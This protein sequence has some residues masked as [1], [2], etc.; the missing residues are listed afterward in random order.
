MR[1]DNLWRKMAFVTFFILTTLIMNAQ[2]IIYTPLWKQADA[3]EQADKP[4]TR[5]KVLAEIVAKATAEDNCGQLLRALLAD[6][7]ALADLSSDSIEEA[8]RRIADRYETEQDA[9]RK[10]VYAS[11]LGVIYQYRNPLD[12]DEQD[13]EKS[14]TFF[15][16][17]LTDL[18]LLARTKAADFAPLWTDG[19]DSRIFGNDLLSVLTLAYLHRSELRTDTVLQALLADVA[20]LY[21]SLGRRDGALYLRLEQAGGLTDS[22]EKATLEALKERYMGVAYNV[23]TYERLFDRQGSELNDTTDSLRYQ[24][25]Q[26]GL[27]AHGRQADAVGLQNRLASLTQPFFELQ[28][29]NPTQL[30]HNEPVKIS[31]KARNLRQIQLRT[32]RLD[33]DETQLWGHELDSPFTSSHAKR[34]GTRTVQLGSHPTWERFQ[35]ETTLT[36][37]Q[38]GL[39]RIT[40]TAEGMEKR[41][42]TVRI[43][44]V[45]PVILSSDAGDKPFARVTPVQYA[46][47]KP[48]LG[49]EVRAYTTQRDGTLTLSSTYRAD[50][51]GHIRIVNARSTG[52]RLY[53]LHT[54][55]NAPAYP[56]DIYVPNRQTLRQPQGASLKVFTD[57]AVYRPGQKM[58]YGLVLYDRHADSL[59]V[60][61][62]QTIAVTLFDANH[63]QIDSAKVST[64][65]LGACGGTFDLPMEALPGSFHLLAEWEGRNCRAYQYFEV[66]AYKRPTFRVTLQAPEEAY[67]PGDSVTLHGTAITYADTPVREA[68]VK[69]G[70]DTYDGYTTAR[71]EQILQTDSEGHFCISLR[72]PQTDEADEI[73]HAIVSCDV[74]SNGG[75]TQSASRWLYAR[76]PAARLSVSWPTL[77]CREDSATLQIHCQNAAG[78]SLGGTATY[79][80]RHDGKILLEGACA[81]GQAFTPTDIL[82]L[83]SGVYEATISHPLAKS[84]TLTFR[85]FGLDDRSV[86]DLQ[87]DILFYT[88]PATQDDKAEVVVLMPQT[89]QYLFVEMLPTKGQPIDRIFCAR[90]TLM[91]F[92]LEWDAS[93]GDGAQL[94][95]HGL[96]RGQYY[97]QAIHVQRPAP[98]KRL[99][100]TW[101]TF[102]SRLYPGQDETWTLQIRHADGTPADASLMAVLYDATLDKIQPFHWDFGL[103]FPRLLRY[104]RSQTV[105]SDKAQWFLYKN[106]KLPT[107]REQKLTQW[108]EQLFGPHFFSLNGYA[109]VMYKSAPRYG[110]VMA[111]ADAAMPMAMR[112]MKEADIELE[113]AVIT[114][115]GEASTEKES[116]LRTNFDETAYFAPA[117]RTDADGRVSLSFRLPESLTT[118]N[119]RAFAHSSQMDY[120]WLSDEAVARKNLMV[121]PRLPRFLFEGD[122]STLAVDIENLATE[123]LD[124]T[125]TLEVVDA[126]TLKALTTQQVPFRLLPN[127]Q[128]TLYLPLNA[129]RGTDEII[130]RALGQTAQGSDGEEHRLPIL[131]DRIEIQNSQAF[132]LRGGEDLSANL[133]ALFRG[134]DIRHE[135]LLIDVTERPLGAAAECLP[136]LT[137]HTALSATDWAERYYAVETARYLA[138]LHP[139]LAEQFKVTASAPQATTFTE[140][141]ENTPWINVAEREEERKGQLARLFDTDYQA[142]LTQQALDRLQRL[143]NG[144]GGYAWMPGMKSNAYVTARVSLLLNR[145]ASHGL[146]T[147]TQPALKRARTYLEHFLQERV[148]WMEKHKSFYTHRTD[149]QAL[150]VLSA[151]PQHTLTRADKKILELWEPASPF[152]TMYE[153]ALQSVVLALCGRTALAHERLESLTEHLVGSHAEGLYFD[154]R[155]TETEGRSYSIPTQTLA[156]EAIESLRPQATDTLGEMRHWLL[157]QKRTQLWATTTATADALHALLSAPGSTISPEQG[158]TGYVT[159][160]KKLLATLPPDS[161]TTPSGHYSLLLEHDA[162]TSHK[163]IALQAHA[164]HTAPQT[165]LSATA[166]YTLPADQADTQAEGM[167]VTQYAEVWRKDK[168]VRLDDKAVLNMGDRVR[169]V[170]TLRADRD[171]DF[172]CLHAPRPANL[173]PLSS[174]SGP[175]FSW[176]SGYFYRAVSDTGV[177]YYLDEF[178]KGSH[179][180]SEELHVDRAGT[181]RC[182]PAT[183]TCVYAPE[184]QARAKS[185]LLKSQR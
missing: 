120:G 3:A 4:Q 27:A 10:A 37:A 146:G 56:L 123:T 116:V 177:D 25:A 149:L 38:A 31:I 180:V 163:K 75:E 106:L 150:Y 147:S 122:E 166:I 112:S 47:G 54:P 69:V 63:R 48:I 29:E 22:A 16:A 77:L 121:Q 85:L 140:R 126:K 99:L 78:N 80:L 167:S 19:T 111:T 113:E 13:L 83:P 159:A 97:R 73:V 118:W 40:V 87:D 49:G 151:D 2:D 55:D 185:L 76:R 88:R 174:E 170:Y 92:P 7:L 59:H 142:L 169:L 178:A 105:V 181:F 89:A 60:L 153:R 110:A 43:S 184:Y 144:D 138:T 71:D 137:A 172:V 94:L 32:D 93:M 131:S 115:A 139:E 5:R 102:R 182:A 24:I 157:L 165:W 35:Q 98:E 168:W 20:D 70:I 133:D 128:T 154:S 50:A 100:L 134:Q 127:N 64:D 183:L 141:A 86:P 44:P 152:H 33:I 107:E 117:L 14:R 160:G 51:H 18:P 161:I 82:A 136:L 125:L 124:G 68:R 57:R 108:N 30:A 28:V 132:T 156:L 6:R 34:I 74:T 12:Y 135:R 119:F 91:R 176:Q 58:Q 175:Y 41:L 46:D 179:T 67:Q 162:L 173:E 23:H 164:T 62:R 103:Q 109:N 145:L 36:F 148:E 45:R 130:V 15:R 143:Q 158:L 26:E 129:P 95:V 1:K 155:R 114:G 21:D 96:R 104:V 79:T 84:E 72:L 53:F 81:V 42:Q 90:D 11:A 171:Y 101:H 61:D 65:A 17:S 66:E 9:V 8:T 39:Y 52:S